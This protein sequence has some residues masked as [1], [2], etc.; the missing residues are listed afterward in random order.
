MYQEFLEGDIIELVSDG[1]LTGKLYKIEAVKPDGILLDGLDL[2]KRLV[3]LDEVEFRAYGET[4]M[5][6]ETYGQRFYKLEYLTGDPHGE[7]S[8]MLCA[9][10]N[11]LAALNANIED[12]KKKGLLCLTTSP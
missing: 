2:S 7:M 8:E 3:T 10:A 4:H 12:T 6:K 5:K 11:E 9:I 1:N